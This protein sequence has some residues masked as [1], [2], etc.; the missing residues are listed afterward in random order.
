MRE[1][2]GAQNGQGPLWDAAATHN[3][4]A[5][6][7]FKY[8]FN[9]RT[10][11]QPVVME[12]LQG[13]STIDK[14]CTAHCGGDSNDYLMHKD[15]SDSILSIPREWIQKRDATY[16]VNRDGAALVCNGE[17]VR[18][19]VPEQGGLYRHPTE[20]AGSSSAEAEVL[21]AILKVQK[22]Q[23]EMLQRMPL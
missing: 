14:V 18:Q 6:K 1:R 8:A 20:P 21:L 19:G 15:C 16:V 11:L 13:R 7:D 17:V 5:G 2:T 4:L 9:I 23:K 3:V 10:L 22:Q 12:G